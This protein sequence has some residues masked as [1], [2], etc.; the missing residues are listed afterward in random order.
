MMNRGLYWFRYDLRLDDNPSLQA[1]SQSVSQL[2]C[3]YIFDRRD[4]QP[5]RFQTQRLGEHR[6]QFIM[7]A[8]MD[9]NTSLQRHGNV[10][11]VLSGDPS[12]IIDQ[13]ITE[14]KID[15]VGVGQHPGFN[16]QRLLSSLI[17][18]RSNLSWI[19]KTGH[20]LWA[21][22]TVQIRV[23]QSAKQS[24][25]TKTPIV[26]FSKFR[27]YQEKV[28]VTA[29]IDKPNRLPPPISG[30][31]LPKEPESLPNTVSKTKCFYGGEQ[32]G[33]DQL[34][35]YLFQSRKVLTYKKTRNQL[36]G[37]DFS[38][39]LSPW[40]AHGCVSPRRVVF[41][42][43]LFEREIESNESTYWLF[44][45]MLWR[46]Y[47]QWLAYNVGKKLFAFR[48]IR[49]INPLQTYYAEYYQQWINGTTPNEWVN[50]FMK[51][52]KATGWMSNRGRQIVA[53]Y[54]VNELGLDWRYGAAYF[55]QQLI[56]YDVASNW[57]NWQYLAGVG[58]D[59]RGKR[60]FNLEKQ[61][62]EYDP[63]GSFRAQWANG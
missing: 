23:K 15:V 52:L 10:L 41:E 16:E 56:D 18:T 55:E 48:G 21:P 8:L 37:W 28:A 42:L 38:S 9:L 2:L 6:H 4:V 25:D 39:K 61:A 40:L 58:T 14:N 1:L 29:P 19:T 20:A 5:T 24:D 30:L 49:D 54:F 34:Q 32:A 31:V 62:K 3:V 47:F 45:E 22:E 11:L 57:G 50:A 12:T 46:D 51:Q 53:S 44:F 26:S 60:R 33:L 17:N 59:P 7:E 27:K 43:R 36:D 35:Y 13:L 63:T